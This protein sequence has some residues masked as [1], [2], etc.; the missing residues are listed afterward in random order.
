[1]ETKIGLLL[2]KKWPS[3]MESTLELENNADKG[4]NFR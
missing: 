1:M 2:A 4:S 3:N